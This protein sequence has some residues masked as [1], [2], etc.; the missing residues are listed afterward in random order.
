MMLTTS[1]LLL[2]VLSSFPIDSLCLLSTKISLFLSCHS[3]L[4]FSA[5]SLLHLFFLFMPPA[6]FSLPRP[7]SFLFSRFSCSDH[8]SASTFLM[9]GSVGSSL[10]K[11]KVF[12]P[13][14]LL[15]LNTVLLMNQQPRGDYACG[16][17]D[18]IL[19]VVWVWGVC[20]MRVGREWVLGRWV[21]TVEGNN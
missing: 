7:P 4:L 17:H 15:P 8:R 2:L 13:G 20:G 11:K 5:H 21:G 19:E 18:Y 3:I 12:A 6:P 16:G 14:Y 9:K 10:N 1:L